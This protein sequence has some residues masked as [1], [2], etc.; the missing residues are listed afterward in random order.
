MVPHVGEK[1]VHEIINDI[2]LLIDQPDMGRMVPEFEQQFLREL[3][4]PPFR[5]VYRR[6]KENIYIVGLGS[7]HSNLP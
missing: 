1:L 6:E 4:R 3:I 5:I 7:G 2:E